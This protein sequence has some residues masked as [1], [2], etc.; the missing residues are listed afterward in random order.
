MTTTNASNPDSRRV[1]LLVTENAGKANVRLSDDEQALLAYAYGFG[2]AAK[3]SLAEPSDSPRVRRQLR[4]YVT[5][6]EASAELLMRSLR[7][8]VVSIVSDFAQ[9]RMGKRWAVQEMDDLVSD[10]LLIALESCAG[11]DQNRGTT[12]AQWVATQLR[13]HLKNMDFSSGGGRIPKEWRRVASAMHAV[14]QGADAH[15]RDQKCYSTGQVLDQLMGNEITRQLGKGYTPAEAELRARDSLSRQ[16]V[17]RAMKEVSE[18][19]ALSSGVVSLDWVNNDE[20]G[21]LADTICTESQHGGGVFYDTDAAVLL[22]V[23][24]VM[25]SAAVSDTT[26]RYGSAGDEV[27]YRSLADERGA[28]WLDI[29]HAVDRVKAAPGAPHAQ[30][31]A[32]YP[33]IQ[34]LIEQVEHF[35]STPLGSLRADDVRKMLYGV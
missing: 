29:R 7:G 24:E 17:L 13:H 31:C 1:M 4:G 18:I 15:M 16:S 25:P 10:G 23:M 35:E 26:E 6:S 3:K 14:E 2:L 20:T 5:T 34:A 32:F 19:R 9:R 30:F 8:L 28:N 11:Y 22:A 21:A 33:H 27:S 12:V